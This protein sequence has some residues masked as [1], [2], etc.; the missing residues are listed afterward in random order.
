MRRGRPPQQGNSRPEQQPSEVAES[1]G[2]HGWGLAGAASLSEP[3]WRS[4]Q[5]PPPRLN[6]QVGRRS[7][8]RQQA[9]PIGATYEVQT[10]RRHLEGDSIHL[11][12]FLFP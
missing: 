9:T 5:V 11:L 2:S 1:L 12:G 6:G 3:G 4:P 10:K 8:K 7:C